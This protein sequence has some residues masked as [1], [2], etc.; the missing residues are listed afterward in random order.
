[1]SEE[2]S[3]PIRFSAEEWDQT[4]AVV[5]DLVLQLME[6]NQLLRARLYGPKSERHGPRSHPAEPSTGHANEPVADPDHRRS[7]RPTEPTETASSGLKRGRRRLDESLE[8]VIVQHEPE[9]SDKQCVCGAA[10]RRMGQE[11]SEHYEYVP[12][13]VRVLRHVR[14]K[15]ACRQ[16]DGTDDTLAESP[17]EPVGAAVTDKPKPS[18]DSGGKKP[19]VAIAPPPVQIIPKCIATE[20]TLAHIVTAKYEDAIPLYRQ[21]KQFARYGARIGRATMCGWLIKLSEACTPLMAVMRHELLAGPIIQC[22]ET[23]L[24]VLNEP[25]RAATTQSYMWVFR[26]GQTGQPVVEFLYA[27][28]RGATV[29][30]EYLREYTGRV[31]TDGYSGYDFL[32]ERDNIVHDGCWAHVRRKFTEVIKATGPPEK[33]R[34]GIAKEAVLKIRELYAIEKEADRAGLSFDERADFRQ[35]RALPLLEDF[36]DWLRELAPTVPPKTLLGQAIGYALHQ[37][38]RLISYV[39]DGRVRLDNNLAENAIRPFVLGRKNWLFS[40]TP[41]GATASARFYSLIETAKANGIEP[42]W[43]LRAI[44]MRLPHAKCDDDY[45]ALLPQ[46]IDRSMLSADYTNYTIKKA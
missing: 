26:G 32:D 21:E 1:M 40:A 14:P 36:E 19:V 45:R 23:T 43:Y 25:N 17:L 22:D 24:Q 13:T 29:A 4:P 16:C 9:E 37:W 8:R 3:R 34:S 18:A 33:V 31:Q 44:F 10:K 30:R 20:S 5:Q 15:Y 2:T 7:D 12:A 28:T 11:T 41:E 35:Q 46:S 42:Y 39:D 38:P 27:Q 6:E